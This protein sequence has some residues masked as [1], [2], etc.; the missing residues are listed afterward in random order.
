MIDEVRKLVTDYTQWLREKTDLRQID[1][2]VEITTPFLDRHNDHIQIYLKKENGS[3]I[4][5][6]DGYT[7][8]D[9]SLSGCDIDSEKRKQLLV[10]AINGFG[11]EKNGEALI[12][13]TDDKH[14][15][16]KKHN[17]IQAILAVNDMFYTASPM[18]LSLF[19]EDVQAWLDNNDI[20]YTPN[21]SIIGKSGFTH[22]YDFVIPKSKVQ[23]E[24]ILRAIN[25]PDRYLIQSLIFS[26]QDTALIRP[27]DSRLF[28]VLNDSEGLKDANIDAL[29]NYDII[30]MPWSI[31]GDYKIQLA[32]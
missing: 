4:L 25:N 27:D 28:A 6:D 9:L 21:I 26:W 5:T 10:Q 14:F 16:Q 20:R 2:Y 24:R 3:F 32:S 17:L 29:I 18:V 1:K 7:I 13:K 12:I 22:S 8:N 19:L 30:A 31:R 15:P 23:P 11:V